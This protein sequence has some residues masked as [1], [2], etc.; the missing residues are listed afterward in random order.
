MRVMVIVKASPSSESGKLPS[1][2]QLAEMGRFNEELA[3]AGVMRSGDGLKPSS[4]GIRVHFSGPD[5]IVTDGPFTETKELIA[6]YWVWE[7]ENMQEAVAWVRKCPNP[8]IEDSDIEIRPF[9]EM[10]DFADS[11]SSGEIAEQESRLRCNVAAKDA[12]LQPYL[13]FGGRC[14]E[15]LEFYQSN[16]GAEIVMQMRWQD[17]PEPM[18]EGTLPEGYAEKI[19]HA[20]FQVG[21]QTLFASDGC[22]EPAHFDGFR[23]SLSVPTEEDAERVFDALSKDGKVDM[24]L[25]QTFWATKYGMATDPFGVGWMVMVP[26][27]Q[28]LPTQ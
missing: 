7:V 23:L 20:T 3:K 8:M 5:R 14:E 11:D 16:L 18:P 13:F 10:S 6:G 1:E 26:G 19:M 9:Y 21:Q 27:D 4:E 28:Q 22:G 2:D 15:A 24:P 17:S 25:T 12:L